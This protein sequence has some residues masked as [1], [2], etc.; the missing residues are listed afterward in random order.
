VCHALGCGRKAPGD[1]I[2][3]HPG[4]VLLKKYGDKVETGEAV[5]EVHHDEEEPLGM[6]LLHGSFVITPKANAAS[7]LVIKV[8][9]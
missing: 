9:E 6:E 8:I 3:Y 7:P 5:M 2:K 1:P 4:V